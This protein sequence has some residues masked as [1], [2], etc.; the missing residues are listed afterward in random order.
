[1]LNLKGKKVAVL[2][3]GVENLPLAKFLIKQGAEVT[4]CDKNL[5][6]KSQISNLKIKN[7]RLG[8]DYLENLTDF[9]IVFR[10]PGLSRLTPELLK[11]ELEGVEISSSIKLF[12]DLCPAKIIGVT[13][14]KGKGTCAALI[15]EILKKSQ[16]SLSPKGRV[17][18][19]QNLKSQ[20]YLAGNIG[21]PAI[22]LL[23]KLKPADW[24]ILELSSF[25]LQDLEKSPHIAIVLNITSDHLDYHKTRQEYV[26]AK[27]NIVLHQTARDF[28]V[29]NADYF[30]SLKFAALT[31]GKVYW[32]S[33][34]KSIDE[35]CFV[36]WKSISNGK[37][38][39]RFGEVILRIKSKEH[40]ICP[41]YEIDLIGAHN[42]E[43]ICAAVVASYLAGAKI[44]DIQKVVTTFS[45]LEHRLEFVTEIN[46]VKYI[47]DSYSTTP[48]TVISAIES[49]SEPIVLICGGRS[50]GG[51]Y[52][53]MV[54]EIL[55]SSVKSIVLIGE[56]AGE[57]EKKL[58]VKKEKLKIKVKNLKFATMKEIVET[59]Q[60]EA[61]PGDIVLF[62]PGCASFD[63]FKNASDRGN[64][65]KKAV[66][67]DEIYQNPKT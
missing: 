6:L 53:K 23:D 49:F 47:N 27:E 11:A 1:M 32:F 34:K 15:Y 46:G 41:T 64:Q 67:S 45:G 65:F 33:R 29:I 56:T 13:G 38:F 61:K 25:Q 19:R 52:D 28:A 9:D 2:G 35:G 18:R 21:N 57:I 36:R 48:E 43:N 42:L 8:H 39:G 55:K 22:S 12:F 54:K 63:M 50:K 44:Q 7:H 3:L 37:E 10:T 40:L 14:T 24:V 66:R 62:S 58:K 4:V 31:K 17:L 30:T 51:N 5:N 16:I 60:R 59:A 26:K 20:I